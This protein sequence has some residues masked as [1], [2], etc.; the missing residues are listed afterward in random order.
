MKTQGYFSVDV[1]DLELPQPPAD[2]LARRTAPEGLG[3]S[4]EIEEGVRRYCY[5][6]AL[7]CSSIARSVIH[8]TV[9]AELCLEHDD[10]R[11]F[12]D[13]S[14]TRLPLPEEAVGIFWDALANLKAAKEA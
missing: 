12:E 11:P 4:A 2:F 10:F 14:I 9:C 1:A 7:D 6:V 5:A 3:V 13:D 8:Q